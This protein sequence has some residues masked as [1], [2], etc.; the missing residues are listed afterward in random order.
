MKIIKSYKFRLY[1]TEEQAAMLLQHGGNSRFVWNKLLEFSNNI[2]KET[3]K[4]PNQ[5]QLQKQIIQIK[6][7]NP[8]LKLSHSQPIQINALR[9]SNTISKSFKPEIIKERNA[10]IAK[11]NTIK[12]EKIRSQSLKNAFEFALPKFKSKN[13]NNDSIF[14]PQN[15]IIKKTRI[16][17][18]KLKW[19]NYIKHREIE[20][21]PL[22]TT[23][24]KD[25]NQFYVSISCEVE[26]EEKPSIP[27]DQANI[28]GIDVGLKNF[29]TLSDGTIIENPRTLKYNLRKIKRES[30]NL[31]RKQL[32][33]TEKRTFDNKIIKKSSN[34]R[35]KQIIKVQKI[36]R[37][38]R[39]IRNNFLH[40]ITHHIIAKYDG[41][42]LENLDIKGMLK[43]NSKA[44]NRSI[45]DVSW[46]EFGRILEYK[47][48]WNSKYFTKIDQYF[49]STQICNNCGNQM[50]L[51]LKDR[52]YSCQNCEAVSDRDINASK[53]IRDG[54]INKLKQDTVATTGIKVCGQTAIAGWTKQKK[55]KF[56][57]SKDCCLTKSPSL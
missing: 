52:I 11:A 43:K 24:T 28:V 41:I 44:M 55:R 10:K 26:I 19:I 7:L 2:K 33:E 22:F 30:K 17:L 39:N 25:G 3:N 40:N 51:S 20:G 54:G 34:N 38:I 35:D 27:L 18:P 49:A 5:S 21:K 53:N 50:K 56:Q 12:D 4:Y 47:S 23:I 46:Y 48:K 42:I 29:A 9:L 13:R 57:Q 31:K 45:S 8:F 37:K 16:Y 14:Y 36:H 15:F 6:A 32:K 1:P